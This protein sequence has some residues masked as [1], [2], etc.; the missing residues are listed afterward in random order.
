MSCFNLKMVLCTPHI[1][2]SDLHSHYKICLHLRYK[3]CFALWY[4]VVSLVLTPESHCLPSGVG[5]ADWHYPTAETGSWL[6]KARW[7]H[8]PSLNFLCWS[9]VGAESTYQVKKGNCRIFSLSWLHF[10]VEQGSLKH[11]QL[12]LLTCSGQ[13]ECQ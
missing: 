8:G 1:L 6:L 2:K 12:A 3:V 5:E 13:L 7:V 10:Q 4:K 11:F 9:C